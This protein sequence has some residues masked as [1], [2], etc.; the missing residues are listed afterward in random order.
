MTRE[1]RSL[2]KLE[3][4][5]TRTPLAHAAA[6][7]GRPI[8]TSRDV[9]DLARVLARELIGSAAV[10]TV[11]ALLVDTRG[12]LSAYYEISR[13]SLNSTAVDLRDVFR[14]ACVHG[15]AAI[16]LAH[17]HPSGE[18]IPSSEDRDF[19]ERAMRAGELLGVK[20]LDHVIVTDTDTYS[21]CDMGELHT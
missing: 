15:A 9:R 16:V 2:R 13:G 6:G 19:T 12:R 1:I 8:G 5:V 18:C 14:I 3:L 11:L 7:L 17:N 10:E 21:M 4:R 20:I